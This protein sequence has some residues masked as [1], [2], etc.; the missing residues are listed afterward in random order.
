MAAKGSKNTTTN[1]KEM[2]PQEKNVK[3]PKIEEPKS[4][5]HNSIG[6]KKRDI[7]KLAMSLSQT[8]TSPNPPKL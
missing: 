1:A 2:Q 3:E 4:A 6:F 8:Q 7:I 5:Y